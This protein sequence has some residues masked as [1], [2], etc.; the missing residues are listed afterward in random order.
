MMMMKK[1]VACDDLFE[2]LD[3]ELKPI[4]DML[5]ETK[6][7]TQTKAWSDTKS[8]QSFQ[9]CVSCRI[10]YLKEELPVDEHAFCCVCPSLVKCGRS[11]CKGPYECTHCN[12]C[13]KAMCGRDAHS[14]T[15][16]CGAS[17]IKT[18]CGRRT[19]YQCPKTECYDCSFRTC[20]EHIA[21]CYVC[22][23]NVCIG[24][25]PESN[26]ARECKFCVIFLCRECQC[27][28]H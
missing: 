4:D 28:L 26:C 19:C 2:L 22:S 20:S 6:R 15:I 21:Q 23:R 8:K 14:G 17:C 27:P 3:N 16:G 7:I 24:D 10:P 1:R 25:D 18:G 5:R 13:K 12:V 11:F 9:S